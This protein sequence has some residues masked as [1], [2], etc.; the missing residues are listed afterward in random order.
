MLTTLNE[1]LETGLRISTINTDDPLPEIAETIEKDF[2]P[3]LGA[4]LIAALQEAYETSFQAPPSNDDPHEHLMLLLPYVQKPLA[5]FAYLNELP[6]THA[7]ITSAGVRRTTTDSMPT[8]YRWEYEKVEQ[9]LQERAH[10]S[11]ETMLAFLDENAANYSDWLDQNLVTAR[12]SL[13]L[14]NGGQLAQFVPIQFPY[15]SWYRLLP[16]IRELTANYIVSNLTQPFYNELMGVTNTDA[17]TLP[18]SEESKQVIYSLQMALANLTIYMAALKLPARFTG[19]GFT[20][21]KGG[22]SQN[23]TESDAEGQQLKKIASRYQIDGNMYLRRAITYLNT[24]ASSSLFA[25]YFQSNK[26]IAP[27]KNLMDR[28]NGI[29]KTFRT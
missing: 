25:S 22:G 4:D 11:M 16:I 7:R 29:R 12:K 15:Y 28:K 21:I 9:Y 1:V 27:T 17:T 10:G 6:A 23:P 19:N 13:L 8:A 20:I 3:I 5:A 26:Y 14:K 2:K 18:T 24:N